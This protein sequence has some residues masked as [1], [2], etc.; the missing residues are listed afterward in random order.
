M[1][2]N[3][4]DQEIEL[5]FIREFSVLGNAIGSVLGSEDRRERIRVAIFANHLHDKI[6]RDTEMTYATAYRKCYGR[7]LEM[8]RYPR[9]LVPS[10]REEP[11]ETADE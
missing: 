4:R 7:A 5:A 3:A 10:H 8:R 11:D 2:T 1:I 9:D 6:F